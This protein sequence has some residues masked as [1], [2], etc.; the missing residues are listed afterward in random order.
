MGNA[1]M[2]NRALKVQPVMVPE[3]KPSIEKLTQ[4]IKSQVAEEMHKVY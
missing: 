2:Q 4:A 3:C 1:L